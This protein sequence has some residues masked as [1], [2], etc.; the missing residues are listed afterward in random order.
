MTF[1]EIRLTRAEKAALKR[2]RKI[3]IPKAKCE[4]LLRLN[5][6]E[7]IMDQRKAG[8]ALVSS[9]WC[10]ITPLG[11]DYLRYA[12]SEQY[13]KYIVPVAV[14]VLTTATANVLW[15]VLPQWWQWL[16]QQI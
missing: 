15:H 9:G 6:V 4:R 12:D 3:K 16:L 2:S 14:S 8:Y 1:D 10:E 13:R 11:I 5:L 7:E